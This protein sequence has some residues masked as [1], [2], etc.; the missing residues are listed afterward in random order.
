METEVRRDLQ[1]LQHPQC[2]LALSAC[3]HPQMPCHDCEAGIGRVP[4]EGDSW[5][6]GSA[7]NILD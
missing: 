6:L 3:L 4:T 5:T 7:C 2:H 1:W